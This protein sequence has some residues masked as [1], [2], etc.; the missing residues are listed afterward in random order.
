[1]LLCARRAPP[2]AQCAADRGC[3][4]Q[5]ALTRA[6]RQPLLRCAPTPASSPGFSLTS[7]YRDFK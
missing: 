2:P 1:M 4:R 3:Q 5:Q 6:P 7:C